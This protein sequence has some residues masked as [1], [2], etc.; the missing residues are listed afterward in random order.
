MLTEKEQLAD[1]LTGFMYGKADCD[2]DHTWL[3]STYF[4]SVA[5]QI[6]SYLQSKKLLHPQLQQHDVSGRSEQLICSCSEDEI[7]G[8]CHRLKGYQVIDGKL[9]KAN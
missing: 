7:C 4:H 2:D 8:I 9:T 6:L 3:E 5:D 1:E